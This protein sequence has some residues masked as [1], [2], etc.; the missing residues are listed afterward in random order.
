M[1]LTFYDRS[2]RKGKLIALSVYPSVPYV[3]STLVTLL[4]LCTRSA[5]LLLHFS[6]LPRVVTPCH[7]P[8]QAISIPRRHSHV[9]GVL[10]GE[11]FVKT[12]R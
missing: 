6:F 8:I 2:S 3:P 9:G 5:L 4:P 11:V 7:F 1:S 10:G 12:H